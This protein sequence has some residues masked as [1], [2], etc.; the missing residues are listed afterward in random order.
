MRNEVD[1]ESIKTE[2][3]SSLE[4][5]SLVIFALSFGL[6]AIA[7]EFSPLFFGPG[8]EPCAMLII[9]FAPAARMAAMERCSCRQ[10]GV[11]R[12]AASQCPG[13]R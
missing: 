8:F 9:A 2:L 11:V 3:Y 4:L 6:A 13:Q 7:A 12:G 1:E 10:P 5:H